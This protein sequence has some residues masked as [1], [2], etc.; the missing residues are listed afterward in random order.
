MHPNAMTRTYSVQQE[1]D[2]TT[3]TVLSQMDN[4]K[5]RLSRLS[6]VAAT[7]PTSTAPLMLLARTP[8]AQTVNVGLV[9]QKNC[10]PI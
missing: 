4:E 10:N 9:G 6:Q 5:F 3:G 8:M 7:A 1:W 2:W